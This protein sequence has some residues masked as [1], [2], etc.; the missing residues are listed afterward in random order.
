MDTLKKQ[1]MASDNSGDFEVPLKLDDQDTSLRF[2]E[3]HWLD[4]KAILSFY[5]QQSEE[6][7]ETEVP[8]EKHPKTEK[9]SD[10]QP[11]VAE[12]ITDHMIEVGLE[13]VTVESLTG[14][15]DV[16]E[17]AAKRVVGAIEIHNELSKTSARKT[18]EA[19][20]LDDR[21]EIGRQV[22]ELRIN[23]AGSKSMS[24]ARIRAKLDLKNDE[25]HKVVRLESH[26]HES[27]VERIESFEDG[28]EYNGKLDVLLGFE[29]VGELANRIEACKPKPA[30]KVE[31]K[32]EVKV[33]QPIE[34]KIIGML[35]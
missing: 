23:A 29:P 19:N 16:S 22:A 28:W 24:W 3:R 18:S 2:V 33:E 9:V 14:I 10:S 11:K 15:K 20:T 7:V 12:P 8:D 17:S 4:I 21:V 30:P 5:E 13:A 31:P 27:V 34:K 26:F 35:T 1:L 25:F 32:E 6:W